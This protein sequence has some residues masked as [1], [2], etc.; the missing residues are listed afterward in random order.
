[1]KPIQKISFLLGYVYNKMVVAAFLMQT[2]CVRYT[3]LG[4]MGFDTI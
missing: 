2:T 3:Q 4:S 1:M